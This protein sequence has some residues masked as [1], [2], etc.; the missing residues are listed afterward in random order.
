[1][2]KTIAATVAALCPLAMTGIV[3]GYEAGLLPF[4]AM[5]ALGV[6][7]IYAEWWGLATYDSDDE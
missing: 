1:M 6:G 7:I 5:V 3:G 4:W 2:K